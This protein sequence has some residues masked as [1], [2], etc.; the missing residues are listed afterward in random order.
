M[1]KMNLA[2]VIKAA[3]PNLSDGSLRTYV[4]SIKRIAPD[5]KIDS[6]AFLQDTDAVMAKINTFGMNVKRSVLTA[7]MVAMGANG[8]TGEAL[9]TYVDA[10]NEY[11]VL[12]SDELGKNKKSN[13]QEKNWTK[14]ENLLA[15][16]K[17]MIKNAPGNQRSLIA[18]LYTYQ[19]PSRLDFY[20][21]QIIG[22]G[23]AM[24]DKQ[25]YLQIINRNKKNFIFNDYKNSATYKTVTIP[26][27]KAMN[28]VLNKYFKLNPGIKYLLRSEKQ[29]S[30][31]MTRNSLGKQLP[32]IFEETGKHITLNQIRHIYIS[33][34]IDIKKT[35][36]QN[37]LAKQMMHSTSTQLTY[38][39]EE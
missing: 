18:A 24:V 4:Q 25:N 10:L 27:N 15:I 5:N 31:P 37:E 20:D 14:H 13:K 39:K 1:N 7:I 12:V 28:T 33:E 6:L 34:N 23:D 26:V 21:M 30:K 8:D 19:P 17:R 32:Q 36:Q 3:R 16:A 11:S 9:R 35:K 22:K 29:S 2:E 38:A